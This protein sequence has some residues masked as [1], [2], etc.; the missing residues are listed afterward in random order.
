MLLKFRDIDLFVT[1][2]PGTCIPIVLCLQFQYV[3]NIPLLE[4]LFLRK[5][6]KILFIESWCRVYA[7][8]LSGKIVYWLADRFVVNWE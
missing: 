8:S 5:K 6:C 7:L 1:N 4:W 3:L 2:G